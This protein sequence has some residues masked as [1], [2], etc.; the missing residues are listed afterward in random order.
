MFLY[1]IYQEDKNQW[2][3]LDQETISIVS[4]HEQCTRQLASNA[5]K[6]AKFH[7]S[8]HQAE[9]Y[10]AEI[11]LVKEKLLNCAKQDFL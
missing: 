9:M 2:E 7:S 8:L 4:V 10:F 5:E 3:N 1:V 11:A 6:N